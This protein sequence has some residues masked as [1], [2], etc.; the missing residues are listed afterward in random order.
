LQAFL[1]SQPGGPHQ[2]SVLRAILQRHTRPRPARFRGVSKLTSPK[3]RRLPPGL[4][5]PAGAAS[6]G[7]A[8]RGAR[9]AA[10]WDPR[11][12]EESEARGGYLGF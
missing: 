2:V 1:D 7:L 6:T 8:D 11:R 3:G 4:G 5:Y 12:R 9:D 10:T